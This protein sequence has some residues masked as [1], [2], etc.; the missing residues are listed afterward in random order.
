MIKILDLFST[1]HLWNIGGILSVFQWELFLCTNFESSQRKKSK[2]FNFIYIYIDDVLSPLKN[3]HFNDPLHLIYPSKHETKD[4]KTSTSYLN[5]L[6]DLDINGRLKRG[7]YDKPDDFKF[8][9]LSN[10]IHSARTYGQYALIRRI[11]LL[12]VIRIKKNRN[13]LIVN[14]NLKLTSFGQ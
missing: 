1:T 10:K 6:S 3:P 9:F 7:I 4:T 14:A 11:K 5:L 2:F 8:P 12:Y 13:K